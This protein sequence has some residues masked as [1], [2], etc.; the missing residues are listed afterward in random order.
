MRSSRQEFRIAPARRVGIA[1]VFSV[2]GFAP[3]IDR[4]GIDQHWIPTTIAPWIFTA[5]MFAIGAAFLHFGGAVLVA[6]GSDELLLLDTSAMGPRA[7]AMARMTVAP[8]RKIPYHSIASVEAKHSTM[9]G[10]SIALHLRDGE[11]ISFGGQLSS[12]DRRAV[13]AELQ[14]RIGQPS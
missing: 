1:C 2:L 4:Y 13:L 5:A 10:D 14:S 11:E 12:S 7:G 9:L 8:S 6:F 3:W